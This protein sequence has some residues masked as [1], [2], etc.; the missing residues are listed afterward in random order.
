MSSSGDIRD[1]LKLSD[2]ATLSLLSVLEE[3]GHATQRG[4]AARIGVA[5][6]LTNTL[7]KRAIRKGL[8]KVKDA[9]A[10][11]FAYYVTPKGF[12]EKGKLVAE[13][14]SS[15]LTFYRQAR[16]EYVDIY[17]RARQFGHKRIAL[18]GVGE[19]AEIAILSAQEA[20]TE[21]CGM[22][23][24][25]SNQVT[26]SDL[27]VYSTIEAALKED[28]DAVVIT[29]SDEPQAAYDFLVQHLDADCVF[30]APMLHVSRNGASSNK[31]GGNE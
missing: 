7:M 23:Q 4:L 11:R 5:L 6:G 24:I 30:A 28:V 2:R 12:S 8:V 14:L 19:L 17:D 9:P 22:I 13:Y 3:D 15:S 20:E 18:Y 25:G 29:V 26:F 16:A 27:S 1:G 10:K 21:L 31:S